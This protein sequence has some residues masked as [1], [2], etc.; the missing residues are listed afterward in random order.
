MLDHQSGVMIIAM[1]FSMLTILGWIDVSS[2]EYGDKNYGG[3]IILTAI[4]VAAWFLA[5]TIK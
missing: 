1:A 4:S 3:L 2:E 5:L